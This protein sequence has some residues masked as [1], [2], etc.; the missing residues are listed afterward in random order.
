MCGCVGVWVW[1]VVW[2]KEHVFVD[3]ALASL[4]SNGLG[5]IINSLTYT[6]LGCCGVCIVLCCTVFIT[7][8]V[9]AIEHTSNISMLPW[10]MDTITMP[11][12]SLTI[13]E[14]ATFKCVNI[15]GV[16]FI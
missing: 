16:T 1:G 15:P 2:C 13:G 4:E 11:L 14:V 3:L 6:L 7:G 9:A 12:I 5:K 10:I 8:E